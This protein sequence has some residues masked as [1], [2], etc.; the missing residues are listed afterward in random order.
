MIEAHAAQALWR[1][2]EADLTEGRLQSAEQVL[3]DLIAQ[4]AAGSDV[5][6]LLGYALLAQGRYAEGFELYQARREVPAFNLAL[7][8]FPLKRWRGEPLA[9]LSLLAWPEQGF[10]DVIMFARFALHLTRQGVGVTMAVPPPLARLFSGTQVRILPIDGPTQI[11]NVHYFTGLGDLPHYCGTRLETL[12][13][14]WP[15]RGV[16][17]PTGGRIGI[18]THGALDHANDANR[19]LPPDAAAQLMALHGAIS[20]RPE[21]TG[22]RDFQ[23]TADIVAGLERVITVDTAVAHLA[24]SMG[25]ATSILLPHKRTDWRWMRDRDHTAWYPSARLY[26]QTPDNDWSRA[27]AQLKSDLAEGDT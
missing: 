14:P 10:G 20:L 13:A 11:P 26:W 3:R 17:R 12:P 6:Y 5:R 1:S 18:M 8:G 27:I 21:D 24:G 19:S 7:P 4:G 9:G 2:A 25:K 23:D 16:A 22:A 15:V